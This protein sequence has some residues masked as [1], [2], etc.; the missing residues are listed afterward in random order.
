VKDPDVLLQNLRQIWVGSFKIIFELARGIESTSVKT[1]ARR[2]DKLNHHSWSAGEFK[3]A[4]S[5]KEV[6][7]TPSPTAKGVPIAP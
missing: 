3:R 2:Q 5:Y 7:V 6:V 1:K 4:R